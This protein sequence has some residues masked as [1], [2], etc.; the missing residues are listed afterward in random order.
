MERQ[1]RIPANESRSQGEVVGKE[2]V[3]LGTLRKLVVK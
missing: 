2:I 1:V 3:D